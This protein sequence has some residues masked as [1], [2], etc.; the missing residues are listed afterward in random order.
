MDILS[1]RSVAEMLGVS[2]ATVK[3]WSDAGTLKCFRTPGGH[4]KFRLRDV[5]SFLSDQEAGGPDVVMVAA[6]VTAVTD[7]QR[8]VRALALSGDVDAL[9]SF[10]AN[11]RLQ[12]RTLAQT[13]DTMVAPAMA[14]IGE[15][16]AQGKVSAAQEHMASASIIDMVARVRP[17]VERSTRSDRGRALC[18]CLGTE[19][20]DIG[21]RSVGLI[22]AAEGYKTAMLGAQVPA[23]D[24]AMMIA[25]NPPSILAL[26]AGPTADLE[27]T[28]GDLAVVASAAV[29]TRTKLIL[30]G[31]GF[32]RL[33]T[34]P[35]SARRFDSLQDLVGYLTRENAGVA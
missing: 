15:G 25:G 17:L 4:R 19:R 8:E 6:P 29:A 35:N 3:R 33:A 32:A 27:Q 20:H 1:T 18:A 7:E 5:R 9:V 21:L 24:L 13:F 31:V 11:Q 28:R 2:E 14:D 30:G 34:I 26:S 12:G 22:L 10:V 23:G 16:W